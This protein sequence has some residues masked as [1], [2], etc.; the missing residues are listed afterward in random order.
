MLNALCSSYT[1]FIRDPLHYLRRC[2]F[3]AFQLEDDSDLEKCLD[4]LT[5][6]SESYRAAID[7][8]NPLFRRR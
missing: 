1:H 4:S 2:G 6:I 3:N 5:D 8:Q 7:Q